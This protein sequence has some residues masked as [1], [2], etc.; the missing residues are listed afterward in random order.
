MKETGPDHDK[1]FTVGVYLASDLIGQGEGKSKQDAEQE[2]A[3]NAL[4]K[5]DWK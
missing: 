4:D 1:K 5:K 3:I 2:A